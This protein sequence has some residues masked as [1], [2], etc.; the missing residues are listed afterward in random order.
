M[1]F[2]VAVLLS[3][4]NS[5]YFPFIFLNFFLVTFFSNCFFFS[6]T[7]VPLL[8]LLRPAIYR[9]CHQLWEEAFSMHRDTTKLYILKT[10]VAPYFLG[11]YHVL[12]SL[13]K[14]FYVDSFMLV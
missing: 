4:S 2:I 14:L 12:F 3:Y 10:K 1:E 13:S 5:K 6:L 9:F 11:A 8:Y 7:Y